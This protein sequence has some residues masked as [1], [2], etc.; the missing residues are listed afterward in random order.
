MPFYGKI[1]TR[2]GREGTKNYR[3]LFEIRLVI[4]AETSQ[5][6][7]EE[8]LDTNPSNDLILR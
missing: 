1:I 3:T 7:K 4:A 2:F 5:V 6:A 8:L